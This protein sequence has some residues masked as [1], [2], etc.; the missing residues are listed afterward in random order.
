M[1]NG[2]NWIPVTRLK[3]FLLRAGS[4]LPACYP[5]QVTS[6]SVCRANKV[7]SKAEQTAGGTAYLMSSTW[8]AWLTAMN[9]TFSIGE[10]VHVSNRPT[11]EMSKYPDPTTSVCDWHVQGQREHQSRQLW[12]PHHHGNPR[13]D[14]P[15]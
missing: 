1:L 12:K 5:G 3:S 15:A 6:G 9:G 11:N 7:E 2:W 10:L 8:A 4:I 13:T 14:D